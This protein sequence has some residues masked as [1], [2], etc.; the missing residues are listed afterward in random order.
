MLF[1]KIYGSSAASSLYF[2]AVEVVRNNISFL[3]QLRIYL[4]CKVLTVTRLKSCVN[5]IDWCE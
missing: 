5:P 2:P 1:H 3:T 4:N